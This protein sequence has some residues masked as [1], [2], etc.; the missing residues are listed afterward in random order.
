MPT[1]LRTTGS[2][3]APRGNPHIR[4]EAVPCPRQVHRATRHSSAK[5]YSPL[6]SHTSLSYLNQP[7]ILHFSAGLY[8]RPYPIIS[9]QLLLP[10]RKPYRSSA[11]LA[12]SFRVARNNV[13]LAVSSVVLNISPIVRSF[14]PW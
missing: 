1:A 3:R 8:V 11:R 13:F 5:R 6:R 9:Y 10:S 2:P 7:Q 14:S 12:R 4:S